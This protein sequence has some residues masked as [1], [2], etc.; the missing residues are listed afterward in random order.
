[1][2]GLLH[3]FLYESRTAPIIAVA[4]LLTALVTLY[5]SSVALAARNVPAGFNSPLELIGQTLPMTVMP[6]Y[7][8][9][10]LVYS[11]RL[12]RRLAGEIDRQNSAASHLQ[13]DITVISGVAVTTGMS[14]GL[15]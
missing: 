15:L 3:K 14:V 7:M 12:S 4:L 13:V 10:A 5:Y 1:M 11:Q 2:S 6:V 9:V 8:L